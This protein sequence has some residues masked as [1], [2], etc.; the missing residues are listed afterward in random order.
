MFRFKSPVTPAEISV[1]LRKLIEELV[2]EGNPL[3]VDVRPVEGAPQNEC[4]PIVEDH[5]QKYGGRSLVGWSLWE[6]PSLFVEAEF[7][8]IWEKPDGTLLDIAPKTSETQ[9]VFFLHAPQMK[10]EGRPADNVRR[11]IKSDPLLL[12]YFVTFEAQ[13]ELMNRGDRV[14]QHG[15]VTLEGEEAQEYESIMRKR[16]TCFFELKS[17]YPVA[18]PYHPC[19]CGSGKKIKWCHKS[20]ALED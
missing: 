16:A 8:C 12:E 14:G 9:R 4:F 5:V 11:A 6:L 17:R 18:G 20:Y 7:H 15:E 10:Y 2:P 19:P 1:G 3:Y 13:F